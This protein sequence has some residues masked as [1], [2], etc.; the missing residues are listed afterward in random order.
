MSSTNY[1]SWKKD[2]LI[3]E[4]ERRDRE[5]EQREGMEE[6]QE[7]EGPERKKDKY[8]GH[9]SIA[10]PALAK[11]LAMG[12]SVEEWTAAVKA[13]ADRYAV[14]EDALKGLIVNRTSGEVQKAA[15]KLLLGGTVDQMLAAVARTAERIQQK[16]AGGLGRKRGETAVEYLARARSA[17]RAMGLTVSE[18]NLCDLQGVP[19]VLTY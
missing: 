16:E 17:L 11:A 7:A 19:K 4:L 18:K 2:Q 1:S 8:P 9:E 13:V 12:H 14:T 3:K 15:E 10:V 6:P 5:G